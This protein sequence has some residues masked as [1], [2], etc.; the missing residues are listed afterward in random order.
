MSK[1]QA[2]KLSDTLTNSTGLQRRGERACLSLV[3]AKTSVV[4]LAWPPSRALG[5][6][7]TGSGPVHHDGGSHV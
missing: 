6:G 3:T 2:A 1:T 7:S 4:A 5:G